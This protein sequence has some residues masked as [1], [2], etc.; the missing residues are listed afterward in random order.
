MQWGLHPLPSSGYPGGRS[1][2]SEVLF[3]YLH[4]PSSVSTA[5]DV[6]K[7][8]PLCHETGSCSPPSHCLAS[9][10]QGT[11]VH[12][13]LQGRLGHYPTHVITCGFSLFSVPL[14]WHS[15]SKIHSPYIGHSLTWPIIIGKTIYH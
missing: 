9:F 1:V 13:R 15:P 6:W 7:D 8:W 3:H 5:S 4:F 10:A 2:C 14:P 12:P 11:R